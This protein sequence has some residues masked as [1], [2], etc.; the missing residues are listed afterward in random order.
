MAVN[1][2]FFW[3][4]FVHVSFH[5]DQEFRLDVQDSWDKRTPF[6]LEWLPESLWVTE[7]QFVSG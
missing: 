6:Y 4:E 7:P 2:L 3:G 5:I 1:V